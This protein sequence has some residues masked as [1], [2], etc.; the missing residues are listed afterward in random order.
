[1]MATYDFEALYPSLCLEPVCLLFYRFLMENLPPEQADASLI[2][3]VAYL[4]CYGF[5][6]T[7]RGKIFK[8]VHGV[9][10]GSPI[11]GMLAEI[12]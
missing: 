7:F 3:E 8:Q 1:M 10:I 9:P 6:F 5:Y 12:Y 11:A 4:I 2:R